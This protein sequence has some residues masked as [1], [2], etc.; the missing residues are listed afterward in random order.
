MT[1][2]TGLVLVALGFILGVFRVCSNISSSL[3][4]QL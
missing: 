4:K 1:V 2:L 3:K